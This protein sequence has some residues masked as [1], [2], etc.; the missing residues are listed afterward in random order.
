ME[1]GGATGADREHQLD[2]TMLVEA[3]YPFV[4]AGDVLKDSARLPPTLA[5]HSR[6]VRDPHDAHD[7]ANLDLATSAI[8]VSRGG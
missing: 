8:D 2:V 5:R 1:T 3:G 4:A 7:V 6:E